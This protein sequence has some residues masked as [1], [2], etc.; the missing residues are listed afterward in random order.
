MLKQNSNSPRYEG[1]CFLDTQT[2]LP[3][4]DHFRISLKA[5]MLF[6]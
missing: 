3:R 2:G 1:K 5:S 6:T 4:T